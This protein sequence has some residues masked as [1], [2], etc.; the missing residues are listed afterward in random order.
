MTLDELDRYINDKIEKEK[1]FIIFTYYE[2][3]VKMNLSK[4]ESIVALDLIKRKLEN[5]QYNI[6][7]PGDVYYIHSH[8]RTVKENELLV[9][10]KE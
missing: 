10:I 1:N 4:E 9:A 7:Y 2:I 8:P 3:R 5:N 6:L